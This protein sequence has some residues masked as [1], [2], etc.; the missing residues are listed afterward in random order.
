MQK[1]DYF[2]VVVLCF[3]SLTL[4]W[5][6]KLTNQALTFAWR[7]GSEP[8]GRAETP[9]ARTAFDGCEESLQNRLAIN[10]GPNQVTRDMYL[11]ASHRDLSAGSSPWLFD[12]LHRKRVSCP[13]TSRPC[14]PFLSPPPQKRAMFPYT[15][16]MHG[17]AI[18]CVFQNPLISEVCR[19]CY[20]V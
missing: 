10:P 9:A 5:Q 6:Q 16:Y 12:I 4:L 7:K 14:R 18:N 15:C 20:L 3:G 17:E 11:L 19:K 8:K 2:C 13:S 1:M